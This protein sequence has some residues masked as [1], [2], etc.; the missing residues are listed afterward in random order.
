MDVQ[1]SVLRRA[2]E[3]G[4]NSPGQNAHA[5]AALRLSE[6]CRPWR[7]AANALLSQNAE[8]CHITSAERLKHAAGQ[9]GPWLERMADAVRDLDHV[10]LP[11]EHIRPPVRYGAPQ[12]QQLDD[13]WSVLRGHAPLR[14]LAITRSSFWSDTFD[15]QVAEILNVH[16]GSLKNLEL[17]LGL[18]FSTGLTEAFG[19]LGGL[20][21][22]SLN[23]LSLDHQLFPL[24]DA[25]S[26][27][28]LTDALGSLQ[29]LRSL[30]L[31]GFSDADVL[32]ACLPR[33]PHLESLR[34]SD[35]QAGRGGWGAIA[36][37]LQGMQAAGPAPLRQLELRALDTH[38]VDF[39]SLQP[40]L[41]EMRG[42]HELVLSGYRFHLGDVPMLAAYLP[43]MRELKILDLSD[44]NMNGSGVGQLLCALE[45]LPQLEELN[46]RNLGWD[47]EDLPRLAAKLKACPLLKT[48]VLTGN[49]AQ[50]PEDA[51]ALAAE[52]AGLL[53][54]E[55]CH[56]PI[57]GRE[58]PRLLPT[59]QALQGRRL[60]RVVLDRRDADLVEALRSMLPGVEVS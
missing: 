43:G 14:G 3:T 37:H 18:R 19:G 46:L 32:T 16:K 40:V 60:M 27:R 2:T 48:L 1:F 15:P 20:E 39:A 26:A 31:S 59:L 49:G 24:A 11:L 36:R 29:N 10:S 56:L 45:K 55:T 57:L 52:L 58:L 30:A 4:S 38:D 42:L 54:L 47:G 51:Q 53:Q 7:Q 44:N 9:P 6:V 28:R 12:P 13:A 50:M 34:I 33:L 21:R 8:M 5:L 17:D 35:C 41:S 23:N 22:L 25:N